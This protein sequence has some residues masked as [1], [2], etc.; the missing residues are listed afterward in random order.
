M[1]VS[2]VDISNITL[3]KA[4]KNSKGGQMVYCNASPGSRETVRFTTG[5]A[6]DT[7]A[8]LYAP[9]GKSEP[10][11]AEKENNGR[12]SLEIAVEEGC[13]LVKFV[14]DLDRHI[15][16]VV[17]KRSEEL[18][19]KAYS[20]EM[21]EHMYQSPLRMATEPGKS[22][23]CRTKVSRDRTNV[24]VFKGLDSNG[25][26]S[27]S[28]G[29]VDDFIRGCRLMPVLELGPLWFVGGKFGPT[30]SVTQSIVMSSSQGPGAVDN[31][32]MSGFLV[33]PNTK[34]VVVE[35]DAPKGGAEGDEPSA[36]RAKVDGIGSCPDNDY[37]E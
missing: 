9:F 20:T 33:N 27:T 3:G 11:E 35:D 19:G 1:H 16:D 37:F 6:D 21:V 2:N 36:K 32:G 28:R 10:Y 18:L 13:D 7:D 31:S 12:F 26:L 24:Q 25:Q 22:N 30:L 4:L 8:Y 14:R 29:D 5:M 15:C 17:H 34:I 23:L